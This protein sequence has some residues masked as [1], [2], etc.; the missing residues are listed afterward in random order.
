MRGAGG[1]WTLPPQASGGGE[2][3]TYES[4]LLRL[5]RLAGLEVAQDDEVVVGVEGVHED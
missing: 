4:V 3:H 2:H 5:R 1:Q